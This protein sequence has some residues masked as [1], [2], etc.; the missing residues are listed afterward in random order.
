MIRKTLIGTGAGLALAAMVAGAAWA[1]P[2][3]GP[4]PAGGS[5]MAGHG[6]G[7]DAN[8]RLARLKAQLKITASQEGAW[9]NFTTALGAMHPGKPPMRPAAAATTG[10]TPAPQVFAMLAQRAQTMADNAKKLSNSVAALY[11]TLSPTQRAV[12]DTHIADMH[13][14]MHHWRE[15][16]GRSDGRSQPPM[17][18]APD[19]GD[20]G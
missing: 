12:F 6:P 20:G 18:P 8:A 7:H 4:P 16:H 9:N 5:W 10:L 1:S 17:R 2:P 14:R 11:K 3:S 19:S 15:K 13:A